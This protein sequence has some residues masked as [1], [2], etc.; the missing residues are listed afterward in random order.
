MAEAMSCWSGMCCV[1]PLAWQGRLRSSFE[2]WFG[3]VAL[4]KPPSMTGASLEIL[5]SDLGGFVFVL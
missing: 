2:V 3:S 1:G 5:V 4:F